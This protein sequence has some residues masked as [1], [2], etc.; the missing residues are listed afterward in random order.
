M[1][2]SARFHIERR[3]LPECLMWMCLQ[4]HQKVNH[5]YKVSVYHHTDCSFS[6]RQRPRSRSQQREPGTTKRKYGSSTRM[7]FHW[8]SKNFSV[9]VPV[10]M[11]FKM[12]QQSCLLLVAVMS[13]WLFYIYFI[14]YYIW[15][16][17]P[18][19]NSLEMFTPELD[20]SVPPQ[21]ACLCSF[22]ESETVLKKM[23][24]P[25]MIRHVR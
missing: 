11:Y 25:H 15:W 24:L 12:N 18:I 4:I 21:A 19:E 5:N 8:V 2:Y 6:N 23:Q 1:Q 20:C 17:K 22:S 3:P 9:F 16:N 10:H 14:I 13:F 7:D